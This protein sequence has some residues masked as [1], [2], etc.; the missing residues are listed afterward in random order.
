M[1]ANV[2]GGTGQTVYE[3]LNI[4]WFPKPKTLSSLELPNYIESGTLSSSHSFET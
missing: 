3:E 4:H 1:Y 2:Q